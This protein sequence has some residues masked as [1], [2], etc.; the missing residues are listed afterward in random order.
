[1]NTEDTPL[2][3]QW[4]AE[5]FHR[6][7]QLCYTS[8]AIDSQLA[9]ILFHACA[10]ELVARMPARLSSNYV[11]RPFYDALHRAH[12]NIEI[13]CR[14][15]GCAAGEDMVAFLRAK[16]G[17]VDGLPLTIRR[18]IDEV[19]AERARQD[20]KWG[21]PGHDDRHGPHDWAILIRDHARD[22][23]TRNDPRQEYIAIAALGIAGVLSI[24]RKDSV[25]RERSKRVFSG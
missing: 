12:R 5:Q 13:V 20:E 2:T 7:R 10:K 19:L 3:S 11:S 6:M 16:L 9:S 23:G 24:D 1:M 22:A 15:F 8:P 25:E 17:A 14:D 4:L 21:G 18:V